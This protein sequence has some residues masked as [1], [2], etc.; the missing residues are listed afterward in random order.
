MCVHKDFGVTGISMHFLMSGFSTL[1]H[2]ATVGPPSHPLTDTMRPR[3]EDAI[4]NGFGRLNIGH[5]LLSYSEPQGA[6]HL[7]QP[8][9][10]NDKRHS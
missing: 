8:S 9:C 10:S 3:K 1:S 6:W 4:N 7:V 5:S 2:Q